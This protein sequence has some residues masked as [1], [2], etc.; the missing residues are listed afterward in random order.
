MVRIVI[1]FGHRH[2]L[3]E[4]ALHSFGNICIANS[5]TLSEKIAQSTVYFHLKLISEDI[6]LS[7]VIFRLQITLE[8]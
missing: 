1:Q 3:M 6:Q 4:N 5:N 8:D 2:Q 7:D